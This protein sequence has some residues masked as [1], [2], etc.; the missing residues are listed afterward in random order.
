MAETGRAGSSA[1]VRTRRPRPSARVNLVCLPHAGGSAS[2]FRDWGA[3]M[4]DEIEVHV[5]QYPGR[6]DRLAEPCIDSMAALADAV[7]EVVGPLFDRPVVLFGHSMGASLMYEVTRRCQAGGLLPEL[8]IASGHPAPHLR[9][10]KML[11]KD[12][13]EAL[14]AELLRFSAGA[15]EILESPE[16]REIVLSVL[17]ADYRVI[18]TY[19]IG[20]LVPVR[21]PIA[22]LRGIDDDHVSEDQANGWRLLTESNELYRHEVF[23]GGHFYLRDHADQVLET[24]GGLIESVAPQVRAGKP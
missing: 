5:L 12:G 22:V 15:S 9:D 23:E 20:E 17:R 21:P 11:H 2:F 10:R 3:R 14:A 19:E 7:T 18:E 6:E 4:R 13:D 8:L 24:V 16:M 1:W